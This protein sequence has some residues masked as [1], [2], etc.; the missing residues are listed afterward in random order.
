MH[1]ITIMG[2]EECISFSKKLLKNKCIIISINDTN[3]DTEFNKNEN[4][5]DIHKVWFDDIERNT[6]PK[7][8]LM[9]LDQAKEI[10]EFV[11]KYKSKVDHIIIHC[12]AGISRSGA[13]GCVIARYLNNH[14]NYIW[15]TGRYLPNRYVYK[16]MCVAFGLQYSDEL[17]ERKIRLRRSKEKEYNLKFYNDYGISM[18]DMFCDVIIN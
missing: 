10:K 2:R 12:T 9:T 7:L 17:F 1:K 16:T 14:D 18:D 13:V 5:I 11:D 15:A 3:Y 4:I 6:N 8:N